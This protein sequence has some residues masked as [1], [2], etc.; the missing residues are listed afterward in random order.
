MPIHSTCIEVT[1]LA[2]QIAEALR[3]AYARGVDQEP[4]RARAAL[5]DPAKAV[6]I[7]L[8]EG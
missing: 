3:L 2:D 6:A 1:K 5:G 7:N 8:S 4:A